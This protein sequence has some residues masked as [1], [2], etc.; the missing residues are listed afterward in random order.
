MASVDK[1][2]REEELKEE[3]LNKEMI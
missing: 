3:A 1:I 2:H